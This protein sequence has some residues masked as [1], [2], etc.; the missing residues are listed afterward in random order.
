MT[1]GRKEMLPKKAA[2]LPLFSGPEVNNF[3]TVIK[4]LVERLLPRQWI[5]KHDS[6]ILSASSYCLREKRNAES[7]SISYGGGWWRSAALF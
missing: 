7:R 2:A 6:F 3:Q 1:D 4:Q 5:I